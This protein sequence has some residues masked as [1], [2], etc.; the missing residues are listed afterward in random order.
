MRSCRRP[1]SGS[2]SGPIPTPAIV[3][4]NARE[5]GAGLGLDE[6]DILL[7]LVLRECAHQR[8]YM[9]ATWLRDY[10]FSAIEEYGRG[11]SIDTAAIEQNIRSIDPTN[12]DSM[13]EALS[14]G[15]FDLE[16]SPAQ[17]VALSRLETTLALIEGWVDEVVGQATEKAMPH[18]QALREAVR[19]RRATGGPGRGNLCGTGR[20]GA[21]TEEAA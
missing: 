10:L 3:V 8:L 14:G 21:P 11:I 19:R 9:Q 1:T 17:Q 2:P 20:P 13:Q 5:F 7:Y 6:S 15:L 16:H 12:M 4:S 18:A